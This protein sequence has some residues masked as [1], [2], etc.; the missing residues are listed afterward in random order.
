MDQKTPTWLRIAEIVLGAVCIGS[1]F[2]VLAKPALTVTLII[3]MVG[4]AFLF[5]GI[6]RVISG[7][8]LRNLS[9]STR[10]IS[11]VTGALAIG[12]SIIAIVNPIFAVKILIIYVA[13]ALLIYSAGNIATGASSK[14]SSSTD[15]GLN[16]V[17]G[18]LT[19]GLSIAV[20]IMPGLAIH[21]MTLF[22]SIALIITG[23][24]SVVS[25]IEGKRRFR[26][27]V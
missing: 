18:V 8:L 21:T 7:L 12:I 17:V 15:R 2:V 22:L 5:V 3:T 27:V 26:V 25:G 10:A 9:G 19:V 23:I 4:L 14:T 11:V 16:V 13:F 20:I 24:G 1:S 6:S